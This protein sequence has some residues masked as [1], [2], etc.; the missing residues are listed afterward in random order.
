MAE[1]VFYLRGFPGIGRFD[2]TDPTMLADLALV[3]DLSLDQ[4]E[5]LSAVLLRETGFLHTEALRECIKTIISDEKTG[6]AVLRSLQNI[7]PDDVS[8]VL[9]RLDRARET[10]KKPSLDDQ[11][12]SSLSRNLS[13]LIRDYPALTR[14]E[15]AQR[16]A[17]LTGQRLDSIDLICDI[18]PVFDKTGEHIEGMFPYTR[19]RLV[20]TGA[21]GLPREFEAELSV[22]QVYQLFESTKKAKAKLLTLHSAIEEWMPGRL[23]ELQETRMPE[24]GEGGNA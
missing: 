9:K 20:A 5:R 11:K 24:D 1:P 23:P 2:G 10:K 6:Q 4:I 15:K 14:F 7:E 16:L 13:A 22:E 12:M 3:A 19:L 17:K 18:R 8:L 21:D